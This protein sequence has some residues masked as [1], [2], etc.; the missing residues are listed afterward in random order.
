MYSRGI[1]GKGQGIL[2]S[3]STRSEYVRLACAALIPFFWYGFITLAVPF[4]N[5]AY[6]EN[7]TRFI[8]HGS[9][10]VCSCI[11]VLTIRLIL[12]LMYKRIG[13]KLTTWK[14]KAV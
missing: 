8:E 1:A 6:H 3:I 14:A 12:Q 5:S 2:I 11:V 4:M 9:M 13:K 10:V 7:G